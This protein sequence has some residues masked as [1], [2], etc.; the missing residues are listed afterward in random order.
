MRERPAERDSCVHSHMWTRWQGTRAAQWELTAQTEQK[1]LHENESQGTKRWSVVVPVSGRCWLNARHAL[2]NSSE[3]S[4]LKKNKYMSI[5][6]SKLMKKKVSPTST[7]TSQQQKHPNWAT[8][9]ARGIPQ[10][11]GWRQPPSHEASKLTSSVSQAH[12]PFHPAVFRGQEQITKC[13][14]PK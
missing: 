6:V 2:R 10:K 13:G 1:S 8:S 12:C 5:S 9:R 14:P 4:Y 3:G 7:F 11:Y